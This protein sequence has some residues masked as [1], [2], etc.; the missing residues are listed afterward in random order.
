MSSS[1]CDGL[2]EEAI[3]EAVVV[4]GGPAAPVGEDEVQEA[5]TARLVVPTTSRRIPIEGPNRNH[6][7]R[8]GPESLPVKKTGFASDEIP[9]RRWVRCSGALVL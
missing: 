8:I 2:A 3:A 9:A 6:A 4:P 5:A 7:V 1:P